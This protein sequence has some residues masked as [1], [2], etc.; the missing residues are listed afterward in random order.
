MELSGDESAEEVYSVRR[1]KDM[2][3][4]DKGHWVYLV[5]WKGYAPEDNTWEPESCFDD[6][7]LW[8]PFNKKLKALRQAFDGLDEDGALRA[9]K[10]AGW[11]SVAATETLQR[12][13]DAAKEEPPKKK[14]KKKKKLLARK[15]SE[16]DEPELEPEPKKAQL[17]AV[18]AAAPAASAPA[19][20]AKAAASADPPRAT[21]KP[22]AA[23]AVA[24]S[25]TDNEPGHAE[26]LGMLQPALPQPQPTPQVESVYQMETKKSGGKEVLAY[27][28]H[29]CGTGPEDDSW[30]VATRV[31]KAPG[32]K[33]AIA[34][35]RTVGTLPVGTL[36]QP[37]AAETDAP[38]QKEQADVAANEP[39][40]HKHKRD[41][42]EEA[43]EA[44]A[45]AA[46]ARKKPRREPVSAAAA[47]AAVVVVEDDDALLVQL[48]KRPVPAA[49]AASAAAPTAGERTSGEVTIR[50]GLS[51]DNAS[52]DQ[53]GLLHQFEQW[54]LTGQ[55]KPP[56]AKTCGKYFNKFKKFVQEIF[57][58]FGQLYIIMKILMR[59]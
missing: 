6:A 17:A 53:L 5:R 46:E 19:P 45:Q 32:G 48:K 33:Q 9:L 24:E 58:D 23:A 16:A 36:D 42:N 20:A 38:Q 37:Q 18:A 21:A 28:V 40:K 8:Q 56:T 3:R 43:D 39:R 1:V 55:A 52:N 54:Q 22:A 50:T 31:Q 30:V 11:D 12:Q 4:H 34:A 10:D 29:W 49:A 27:K 51:L 14:K 25:A 15:H 44:A 13:E 47:A 59:K 26:W 41:S 57:G 2:Q 7:T 35:F